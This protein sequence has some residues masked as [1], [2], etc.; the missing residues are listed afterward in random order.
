MVYIHLSRFSALLTCQLQLGFAPHN[1]ITANY[2]FE[3][4]DVIFLWYIFYFCPYFLK[5]FLI[6]LESS[7]PLITTLFGYQ[8]FS[9]RLWKTFLGMWLKWASFTEWSV[10]RQSLNHFFSLNNFNSPNLRCQYLK[11]HIQ[12]G[13]L[14]ANV[15]NFKYNIILIV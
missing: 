9:S 15:R 3:R 8:T 13:S 5:K 1:L 11:W 12:E 7:R 14:T 6:I 10:E 2:F 4:D